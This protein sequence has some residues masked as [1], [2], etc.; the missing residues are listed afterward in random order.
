MVFL[1]AE[2]ASPEPLATCVIGQSGWCQGVGLQS[3]DQPHV[4]RETLLKGLKKGGHPRRMVPL[5]LMNA[6]E[7]DQIAGEA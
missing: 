7:I 3:L 5:T 2:Q 1:Q 4:I 6:V